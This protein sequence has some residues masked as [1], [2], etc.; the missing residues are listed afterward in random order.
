[1]SRKIDIYQDPFGYGKM[2]KKKSF[3]FEPGVT[4][5]VGCNGYGKTP[6]EALTNVKNLTASVVEYF[7]ED[8]DDVEP[9]PIIKE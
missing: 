5:F 9:E 8:D 1:M 6:E 3:E 7:V 2:F 4:V